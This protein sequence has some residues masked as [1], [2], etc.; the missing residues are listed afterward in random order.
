[1]TDREEHRDRRERCH[2]ELAVVRAPGPPPD[3]TS[4]E[5][6]PREAMDPD[7]ILFPDPFDRPSD[8]APIPQPEARFSDVLE[9][10]GHITFVI[11]VT[12]AAP[13]LLLW[14]AYRLYRWL[15]FE[16]M[17]LTIVSAGALWSYRDRLGP[18]AR[19]LLFGREQR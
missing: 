2:A 4:V 16:T 18:L 13:L 17:A 19:R 10:A 8:F 1:M 7:E 3:E 6:T 12:V 5:E 14:A 15:P 11:L 9:L